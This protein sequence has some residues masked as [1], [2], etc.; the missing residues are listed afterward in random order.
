[1][2]SLNCSADFGLGCERHTPR[3]FAQGRVKYV[4]ETVTVTAHFA[5]AVAEQAF[6]EGLSSNKKPESMLDAAFAAMWTPDYPE[7]V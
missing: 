6:A 5:A 2:R 7:F 1:M 3:D 4:T